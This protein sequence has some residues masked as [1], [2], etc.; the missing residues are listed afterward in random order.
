[1]EQIDEKEEGM[2]VRLNHSHTSNNLL[3]GMPKFA[4]LISFFGYIHD[5]EMVTFSS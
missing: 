2:V 4:Y 1:M 5:L 3:L